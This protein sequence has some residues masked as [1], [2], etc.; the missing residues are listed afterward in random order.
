MLLLL[1]VGSIFLGLDVVFNALKN[2]ANLFL[3]QFGQKSLKMSWLRHPLPEFGNMIRQNRWPIDRG[4][5]R[6]FANG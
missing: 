6:G 4:A 3:A 5:R 1:C 2:R